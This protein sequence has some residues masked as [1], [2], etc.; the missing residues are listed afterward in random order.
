MYALDKPKK[1]DLTYTYKKQPNFKKNDTVT[2]KRS[3]LDLNPHKNDSKKI[4]YI[5]IHSPFIQ[6]Q[7]ILKGEKELW[8]SI[9]KRMPI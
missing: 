6:I 2:F 5:G 7:S 4:T 8:E 1:I 9:G 3:H